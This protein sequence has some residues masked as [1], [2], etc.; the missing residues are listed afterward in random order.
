[1]G[2]GSIGSIPNKVVEALK[3]RFNVAPPAQKGAR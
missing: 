1:M 2:A 3:R